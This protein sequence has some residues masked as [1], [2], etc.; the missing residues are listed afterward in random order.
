MQETKRSYTY[1]LFF[2]LLLLLTQVSA[3]NLRDDL[4]N[5][6]SLFSTY[7]PKTFSS[8]YDYNEHRFSEEYYKKKIEEYSDLLPKEEL[9]K[10]LTKLHRGKKGSGSAVGKEGRELVWNKF[11]DVQLGKRKVELDENRE[12]KERVSVPGKGERDGRKKSVKREQNRNFS[13]YNG[14][15]GRN[16]QSQNISLKQIKISNLYSKILSRLK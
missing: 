10:Y 2:A 13:N 15:F 4:T 6:H 3:L 9:S 14:F 11:L 8:F 1:L 16:L 7:Y 12:L 5:L